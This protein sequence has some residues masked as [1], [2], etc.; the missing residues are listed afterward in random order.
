MKKKKPLTQQEQEDMYR[1]LERA[2]PGKSAREFHKKYKQYGYGL[3]FFD[4][5]PNF[6]L[7]LSS[8]ALL[9]SVIALI[10]KIAMG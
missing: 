7:F 5:Y 2:R 8:V 9:V 10:V 4:R 6:H 1:E 3:F